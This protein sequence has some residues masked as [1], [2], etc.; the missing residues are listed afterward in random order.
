MNDL[1]PDECVFV[2]CSPDLTITLTVRRLKKCAQETRRGAGFQGSRKPNF[3]LSGYFWCQFIVLRFQYDGAR[4][5]D[6][7][8][9]IDGKV[10]DAGDIRAGGGNQTLLHGVALKQA[11]DSRFD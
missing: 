7:Q 10:D 1:V 6:G 9:G 11:Q 5:L 8:E 2:A 4:L 3:S